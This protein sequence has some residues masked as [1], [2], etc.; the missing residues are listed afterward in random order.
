LN[1]PLFLLWTDNEAEEMKGFT[2][3]A[4]GT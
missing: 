1:Q 2:L 4:F 3:Q